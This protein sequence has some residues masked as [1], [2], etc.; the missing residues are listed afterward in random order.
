MLNSD[1]EVLVSVIITTH[2]RCEL[3]PRAID[4]VLNQTYSN[5]ELIIVDDGS[6][7]DTETIINTY[8]D[9]YPDIVYVKHNEPRG[10]NAARNSGILKS[11]GDFVA[12]LDDD[13]EFLP[14]RIQ[15][16]MDNYNTSYS[17]IT[18]RSIH[19]TEN[20]KLLTRFVSEVDLE[21]ILYS[22]IIGNQ[23]LVEKKRLLEVDMFDE[24]LVRYQDYDMW[25]RLIEKFGKA[26]MI[27]K[28]T[29]LIHYDYDN[30]LNNNNRNNFI[31]GYDFY[32]KHKKI[33][34]K[35]QR[36]LHLLILL[37]KQNKRAK[38]L[39]YHKRYLYL[40]VRFYSLIQ[41]FRKLAW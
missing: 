1:K 37:K 4:S 15:L 25:L 13:D 19:I 18:S 26:K 7:D 17:F 10:G 35:K 40:R 11:N 33:M 3:L 39:I 34:N 16:L 31:G 22:N 2:N 27:K 32:K 23:I 21:M 41:I 12:G 28:A 29:Q 8:L 20:N 14:D 24:A 30:S 36:S 6:K 9:K 38:A 5:I